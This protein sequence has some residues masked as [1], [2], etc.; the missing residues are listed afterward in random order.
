MFLLTMISSQNRRLKK[1]FSVSTQEAV[2]AI[3]FEQTGNL[4]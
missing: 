3:K 2:T 1:M 4:K